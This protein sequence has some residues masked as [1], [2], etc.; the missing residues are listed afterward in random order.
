MR[1][2]R[3]KAREDAIQVLYQLDLNNTLTPGAGLRH[4]E[5]YFNPEGGPIDEFTRRLVMGVIDALKAVDSTVS[6]YSENWKLD[7]MP[8]VDRNILRL[9]VYELEHCDDIPATVSIN[10][11]VDLAKAFGSENS[12]AFV[13]GILDRV[14]KALDR[15]NKAK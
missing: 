11:M 1:G 10:E 8:A 13:N 15:P 4:F 2:N 3:R 6:K 14:K 12:P 7:R 5:S 9:G